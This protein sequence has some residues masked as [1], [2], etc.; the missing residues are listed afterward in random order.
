MVMFNF[1]GI[2]AAKDVNITPLI[3]QGKYAAMCIAVGYVSL[4]D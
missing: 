1:D 2:E 3:P 4:E